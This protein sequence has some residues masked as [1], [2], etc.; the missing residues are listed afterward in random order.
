MWIILSRRLK[1]DQ[2]IQRPIQGCVVKGEEIR[3]GRPRR[4]EGG[5]TGQRQG[6]SHVSTVDTR[7][8]KEYD[9][10]KK[11]KENLVQKNNHLR[12]NLVEKVLEDSFPLTIHLKLCNRLLQ[13]ETRVR[14][15][16]ISV[17][18]S[19]IQHL[20]KGCLKTSTIR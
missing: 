2:Q 17:L 5:G 11:K 10:R 4:T 12:Y 19:K 8:N 20:V 13:N 18:N 14:I 1:W 15:P 7:R 9:C 6:V 16:Q 3:Y